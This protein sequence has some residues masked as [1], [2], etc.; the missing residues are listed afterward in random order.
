MSRRSRLLFWSSALLTVASFALWWVYHTSR[1]EYRL[2]HGQEAIRGGD[3]EAGE[4]V[5]VALEGADCRDEAILLRAESLL[6]R[7]EA[8]KQPSSV[9]AA[10][11]LLNQVGPES[12]RR[13]ETAC[14]IGRC[15]LLLGNLVEA[16][17]AFAFVLS[18]DPDFV[19]AHRGLMAVYYDLGALNHA[20]SHAEKWAELAPRDGRPYRFIGLVFKDLGQWRRAIAPYRT[21]LERELKEPVRQEVL[22]ELAECLI[23]GGEFSEALQALQSSGPSPEQMARVLTAQGQCY[24]ALGETDRAAELANQA[25]EG[26]PTYTSALRLRAQLAMD[27]GNCAGAIGDL[28]RAAVLAPAEFETQHLLGQ[29]YAQA[30]Q[31]KQAVAAQERVKEIQNQLDELTK[32]G[33]QAMERPKD[34]ALQNKMA[35]LFVKLGKPELAAAR[36]RVAA[37]LSE[38]AAPGPSKLPPP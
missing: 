23:R 17:Q 36:R 29:A 25:L 9:A 14:L 30:G 16:E 5:A 11:Q 27:G 24:R 33:R 7:G 3:Y 20:I 26:T 2:R 13:V 1:P 15:L 31:A 28:E 35:D 38:S 34:A 12:G 22:A 8:A 19:D 6:L 37:A 32:L 4:R 21:A 10:L 18:Q